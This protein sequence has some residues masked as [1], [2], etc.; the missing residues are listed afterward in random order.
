MILGS[1]LLGQL[2]TYLRWKLPKTENREDYIS[3]Y[4]S[5]ISYAFFTVILILPTLGTLLDKLNTIF[6]NKFNLNTMDQGKTFTSLML[7]MLVTT[8]NGI[9][10]ILLMTS[11]IDV[12][13]GALNFRFLPGVVMTLYVSFGGHLWTARNIFVFAT[14]SESDK[15]KVLL[16]C[17]LLQMFSPVISYL[18]VSLMN[19]YLGGNWDILYFMLTLLSIMN[20]CF[21]IYLFIHFFTTYRRENHS[22]IDASR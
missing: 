9:C 10:H 16:V 2:Q 22:G 21:P 11:Q 14:N 18:T 1:S 4:K 5:Q 20:I 3:D 13:T 12:E 19:S 17:N 7:M 15:N 8:T 6:K